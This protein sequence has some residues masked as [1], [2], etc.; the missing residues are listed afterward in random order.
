MARGGWVYIT[1]N[2]Y[3]SGVYVG[4][5][6]DVVRRVYQHREGAGSVH[7]RDFGKTRLVYVEH[8]DEI[9]SAI[10]R[11]KLVKKWR[12]EWKFA[13]IEKDNP[14]WLDLWEQWFGTATVQD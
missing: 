6:A 8:H 5:S 1:A 3:R 11:E 7:G 12:R 13:L 2:R 10:V 9:G 4:V 14:D